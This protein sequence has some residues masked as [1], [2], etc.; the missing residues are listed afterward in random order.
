MLRRGLLLVASVAAC[1]TVKEQLKIEQL[2]WEHPRIVEVAPAAPV[3]PLAIPTQTMKGD[4]GP[5]SAPYPAKFAVTVKADGTI[6]FP[7]GTP[8]KIKGASV[9]VAA[10]KVA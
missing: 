9:I 2:P 6:A 5:A 7:D 1:A 4:K 3:V 10:E 8:G